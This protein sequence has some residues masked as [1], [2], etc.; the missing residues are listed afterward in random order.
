[1]VS[2]F[3]VYPLTPL[4]I[5]PPPRLAAEQFSTATCE[6]LEVT[7][8]PYGSHHGSSPRA[9][10]LMGWSGAGLQAEQSL[11]WPQLILCLKNRQ[12]S[13]SL[14]CAWETGISP[15]PQKGGV[16]CYPSR[17]SDTNLAHRCCDKQ[18]PLEYLSYSQYYLFECKFAWAKHLQL[19]EG[20][21]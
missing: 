16:C 3:T 7:M 14:V 12:D 4:V 15:T 9:T 21:L 19:P 8:I 2:C 17:A 20:R 10:P 5:Q 6:K 13:P 11:G 1:M 18:E